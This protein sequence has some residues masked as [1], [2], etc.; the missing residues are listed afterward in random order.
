M[1]AKIHPAPPGPAHPAPALLRAEG[2]YLACLIMAEIAFA[3]GAKTAL[4]GAAIASRLGLAP[5]AIEKTLQALSRFGLLHSVRG[6]HGGYRLARPRRSITLA[7]IALAAAETLPS[8]STPEAPIGTAAL[9]PLWAE[10]DRAAMAGLSATSLDLICRRA[11]AAGL[12]RP[13][14][15]PISFSI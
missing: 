12:T 4:T 8:R 11:E 14:A 2:I 7:D 1:D 15:E 3:G 10:L 6:P 9:L 13:R 5:R